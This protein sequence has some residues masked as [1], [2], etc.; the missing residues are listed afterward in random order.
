MRLVRFCVD[1]IRRK[2]TDPPEWLVL[3][4]VLM[5]MLVYILLNELLY[6]K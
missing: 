5:F 1:V 4:F 3:V 6:G 2:A